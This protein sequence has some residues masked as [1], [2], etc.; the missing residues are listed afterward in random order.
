MNRTALAWLLLYIGATI[1]LGAAEY[2]DAQQLEQQ[3]RPAVVMLIVADANKKPFAVGTGFFISADGMIVTN[4]HVIEGAVNIMAKT[5]N[6]TL[7]PVT[8]VLGIHPK[9]DIALL[10]SVAHDVPFIE[11]SPASYAT[12]GCKVLVI[13]NPLGHEGK[14]SEG[15]LLARGDWMR[16]EE[17][18]LSAKVA[19]G[20]S[21]SPVLNARGEAIGVVVEQSL[22]GTPR[23]FAL[24]A[25]LPR[26]LVAQYGDGTGAAV[27]PFAEVDWGETYKIR[28]D[29]DYQQAVQALSD[30]NYEI[31]HGLFEAV[32]QRFPENPESW[33]RLGFV[34]SQLRLPEESQAALKQVTTIAPHDPVGWVNLGQ[35]YLMNNKLDDGIAANEEALKWEP[36]FYEAHVDIGMAYGE[37]GDLKRSADELEKAT[38]IRPEDPTGWRILAQV[39]IAQREFQKAADAYE[40]A[41]A[42]D[43]N[44]IE[45]WDALVPLDKRLQRPDR[46]WEAQKHLKELDPSRQ[47]Q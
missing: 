5:E 47:F 22:N 41:A 25:E 30:H 36:N 7:Y 38:Q 29:P 9:G 28:L 17:M 15:V 20:S 39:Y 44:D 32:A 37:K 24:P 46:L 10:Q 13:G 27:R 40:K 1:P 26:E 21:G 6:G 35:S 18:T 4:R 16:A 14:S 33:Q 12:I 31:A 23:S 42:I 11:M 3:A 2:F 43:P 8:G 19:S 45:T 34:C